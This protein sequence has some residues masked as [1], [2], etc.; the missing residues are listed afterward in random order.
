M[1]ILDENILVSQRQLLRRWRIVSRQIGDDIGRAGMKDEEIPPLLMQLQRSPLSRQPVI[2][3]RDLPR[4]FMT[5]GK[6][7]AE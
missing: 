4:I 2:R 1:N 6:V 5:A 7:R 3:I